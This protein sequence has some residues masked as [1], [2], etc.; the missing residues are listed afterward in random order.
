MSTELHAA[1]NTAIGFVGLGI[2]G[3]PMAANLLAAG[4]A[5]K[6]HNRSRPAVERLVEK[7]ASEAASP[8]EAGQDVDVA[9]LML[10]DTPDVEA[11]IEGEG[12]IGSTLAAGATL[13][14]MS[15]ISPVATRRLAAT[16]GDAGVAMLDAPVSGGQQGAIDGTLSIMVG[17][18]ESAFEACRPILNE[19]GKNVTLTGG[20]GAGQVTKACN[21]V[22]VAGTIQIVAEALTLAQRSGVDP[23]TV[24]QA[25]SG[26]FASS[27]ILEVHGQRM[28]DG[29]FEPG[30]KV[31]LHAKDLAIAL[32]TGADAQAPLLSTGLVKQLLT[33]LIGQGHG[34]KDHSSLAM[35]TRQLAGED[36]E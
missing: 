13:I 2:M 36:M 30:F 21:Q 11:V 8:A 1:G 26:G 6:V 35:L 20:S 7:G 24:R 23:S 29:A 19:L 17:G 9:V 14:D 18:E 22:I 4:Y 31:R 34:D 32:E 12:G 5:V 25:L 15:T 3:E 28:L 16:L 10:P 27:K 33:S